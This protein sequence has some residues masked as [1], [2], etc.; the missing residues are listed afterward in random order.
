MLMP[1]EQLPPFPPQVTAAPSAIPRPLAPR[2]TP[3]SWLTEGGEAEG[4][5]QGLSPAGA[6]RDSVHIARLHGRTALISSNCSPP[7]QVWES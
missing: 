7:C 2:A 4:S 6:E 3:G 1:L 5:S